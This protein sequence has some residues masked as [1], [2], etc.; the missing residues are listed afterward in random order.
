MARMLI[1]PE[2]LDQELDGDTVFLHLDSA[3]SCALDDVG[4][5]VWHLLVTHGDTE[6]VVSQILAAYDVDE[7]T[8]RRDLEPRRAAL[9]A[10][11][12]VTVDAQDRA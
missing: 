3:C 8:L 5:R 7:A 12:L 11:G 10:A 6:T 4:T 9:T 1:S 2:T